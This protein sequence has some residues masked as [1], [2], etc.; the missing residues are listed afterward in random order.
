M[1]ISSNHSIALTTDNEVYAWGLNSF[2]QLGVPNMNNKKSTNYLD[3]FI[4][5]PIMVGENSAKCK[6]HWYRGFQNSFISM[7]KNYL[8]FGD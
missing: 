5:T 2:N 6:Y 7:V 4:A 8:C 1:A 3:K